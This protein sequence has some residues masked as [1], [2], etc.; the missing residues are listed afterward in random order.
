MGSRS[1]EIRHFL[2]AHLFLLAVVLLGFG[3]TF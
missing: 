3:R 2:L 1:K